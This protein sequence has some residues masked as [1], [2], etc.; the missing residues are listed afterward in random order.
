MWLADKDME[1]IWEKSDRFGRHSRLICTIM[2]LC[3]L[4]AP[5]LMHVPAPSSYRSSCSENGHIHLLPGYLVHDRD[6]SPYSRCA[7]TV[8]QLTWDSSTSL[9]SPCMAATRKTR[10][11]LF[12]SPKPA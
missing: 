1:W 7:W 5:E 9:A 8:Q 10:L 2:Q 12:G 6:Q 3:P 11:L 4:A